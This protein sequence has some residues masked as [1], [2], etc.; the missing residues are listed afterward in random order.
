MQRSDDFYQVLGVGAGAS[1]DEIKRAYRAL[2]KKYHPDR[3]PED[4]SAETKFKQVQ[5]AYTVLRD[6]KKRGEYDQYGAA[7]VGQWHTTPQ[8]QRVY[9]WGG[10]SN[11]NAE[12][13]EDL[14]GAFGQSGRAS[15][16][17]QFFGQKNRSVQ[18]PTRGRDEIK[19]VSL[20]F[21]QAANGA[22]ITVR[23]RSKQNGK[24]E[25]LDVKIPPGVE[26]GQ[27]I[28]LRGRGHPGGSGGP[29]G[30]LLFECA[31]QSH[32]YFYRKGPDLYVDVPV[33][34]AEATL[35][36][37]IEVPSLDGKTMLSLPSGVPSGTK[38]RLKGRGLP[39]QNGNGQGDQ[40]VVVQ[41]VPSKSLT[42]EEMEFFQEQ[43][44]NQATNPRQGCGWQ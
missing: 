41:I 10:D 39:R 12:D 14:M 4:A 23:L 19:E 9:E 43:L 11:I 44:D 37:K 42:E 32:P 31:I 17:D 26:A 35:G 25:T 5:E 2:A 18:P 38:L 6:P 27:K 29:A 34:V 30:D 16:F 3:N 24:A 15:I 28:R 36:A 33:S 40:Y 8:G 13:L 7:G 22:N 1:Q 20:S 21:E